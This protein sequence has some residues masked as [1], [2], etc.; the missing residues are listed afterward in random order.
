[1]LT[2]R[3]VASGTSPLALAWR[4]CKKAEPELIGSVARPLSAPSRRAPRRRM[5]LV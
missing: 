2:T 5:L 4:C 1:M 3:P